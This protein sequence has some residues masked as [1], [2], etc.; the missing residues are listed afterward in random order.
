MKINEMVQIHNSNISAG[1]MFIN[2][3]FII[4]EITKINKKSIRVHMTHCK[5]TT[6]GKVAYEYD[7]N[8]I[9]TFAYWK[10]VEKDNNKKVS[11]YKNTAYGIIEIIH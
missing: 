1:T 7:M 8:S 3:K 2:E 11:F 6:N 9:A 4:G 10:T 5:H